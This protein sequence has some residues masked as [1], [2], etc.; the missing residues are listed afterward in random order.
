MKAEPESERIA[1]QNLVS[2]TNNHTTKMLKIESRK[3]MQS[4]ST[5]IRKKTL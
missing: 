5:L 2:Q 3:R 4:T 1:A